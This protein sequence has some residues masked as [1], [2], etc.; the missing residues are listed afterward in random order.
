MEGLGHSPA[1]YALMADL[2]ARPA[3]VDLPGWIAGFARQR[4]GQPQPGAE[5]AWRE[6]LDLV[7]DVPGQ[8]R[9]PVCER[10]R[11][12][13]T[14]SGA[15]AE[16]PGYPFEQR[17]LEAAWR[18]LMDARADLGG[19]DAYAYDVVNVARQALACRAAEPYNRIAAAYDARDAAA[20]HAAGNTL[21][22][23]ITDMD[24]L[25]ATREEFLL[26]RWLAGARHWAGTEEEARL[27]EWNARNQIT[28][29]GP[30]GG[31]LFDYA[32]KQWAGLLRDFHRGRWELYLRRLQESLA[33]GTPWDPDAW[34]AEIQ[35]WENAW[36]HATARYPVEPEGDSIEVAL[37]LLEKY[38]AP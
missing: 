10:P 33:A 1:V 22:E 36:T 18:R 21:L 6:L 28:L 30:P 16:Y 38:A 35:E 20:L 13:V 25:V 19:K 34:N 23:L 15:V 2:T 32:A 12:R 8:F 29:W 5:H 17:A 11:L 14:E 4:Y 24:A 27:Y 26:G 31:V 3:A 7:Y 9:S 37:R